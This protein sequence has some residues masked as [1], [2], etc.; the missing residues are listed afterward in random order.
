M[1]TIAY[2]GEESKDMSKSKLKPKL[3]FADAQGNIY[4]HPSLLMLCRRGHE[5]ALPRPDELIPLPEES[6]LFLLPGRHA[7]GLDPNSGEAE[8]LEEFAV[9]AFASPGHTL[10]GTAAYLREQA[11]S[12]PTPVLPLF[13]YGAVGYAGGRFWIAA[14]RVDQDKRQVFS[15]I[16]HKQ[17]EKGAFRLQSLF[18]HNR[19]V[20]HLT[21]CALGNCCPAARNLCLG[22]FEAPLPTARAC[23]AA[24]VGCI[25]LQSE[26]SGFPATQKRIGFRPTP[27][28]ISEIMLHHGANEPRP[29]FSFGQGCEGEPLTE[30]ETIAA[31]IRLFRAKGG[32]GVVNVNTNGSLHHVLPDLAAAGLNSMRVSLN[33]AREPVYQAYY[34]PK[35]Y[36]FEDVRQTIGTAKANGIFVSLN[37]LYFPGLT[38]SEEEFTALADLVA[39]CGV[40]FIQLRNLNLDPERYLELA[41]PFEHGPAMGLAHFRKRFSREFP[42]LSFGYFNPYLEDGKPAAPYA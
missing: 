15:S 27:E 23:N 3:V 14:Q 24:C 35:S 18:P 2:A 16:P 38:D 29:V 13:A 36:S 22:R 37:L 40:D 30:A 33:S 10:A 6:E 26:D 41:S 4:D 17:I 21:H 8:A 7:V 12:Q 39:T 9:A 32:R 28:E 19:L 42:T 11:P 25:S 1:K 31:A 5:Y 20:K 34:R